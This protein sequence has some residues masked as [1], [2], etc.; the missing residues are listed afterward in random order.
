MIKLQRLSL[1]LMSSFLLVSCNTNKTDSDDEI[2]VLIPTGA[3]TLPSYELIINDLAETTST[4]TDVA[5][6]L[7]KGD[8]NFIVFDSVNGNNV[9]S[10][11][12]DSAKYEF[13]KMLTGGNF[14]LIGFNKEEGDK[15]KEDDFIYGFGEKLIPGKLYKKLY[16][17]VGNIQWSDSISNLSPLLQSMNSEYKISDNVVDWAI[18][19]EP[20]LTAIKSKLA[21]TFKD[22]NKELKLLDINLQKE[23]K[24]QNDTWDKDFIPQAGLFVKKDFKEKSSDKY[25][26]ILKLFSN[27]ISTIFSDIP[28]VVTKIN[29]KFNNESDKVVNTFGFSTAL[30]NGVQGDKSSKNGFGIVPNDVTFTVDDIS[31]FNNLLNA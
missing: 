18:V 31:A 30:L 1:F 22:D 10:K 13:V 24:N 20:A 17:G 25:D 27:G 8:Y 28:A 7:S 19:A 3:P 2:Q 11:Q 21:K 4:T 6:Q 29:N 16:K 5:A 14:H 15:P 23:F 9:L 12:G 26:E